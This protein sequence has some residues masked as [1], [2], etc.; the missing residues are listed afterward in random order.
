MNALRY[1]LKP[2][3]IKRF[4]SIKNINERRVYLQKVLETMTRSN[5]D[6]YFKRVEYANERFTSTIEGWRTP[7]GMIYIICGE[8]YQVFQNSWFYTRY[9]DLIEIKFYELMQ[10][11]RYPSTPRICYIQSL[12]ENF[13]TFWWDC[14]EKFR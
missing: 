9:G 12:P 1:I 8:P 2:S 4:D 6:E 3:E 5:V 13:V 7:M 14:V 11:E 10:R